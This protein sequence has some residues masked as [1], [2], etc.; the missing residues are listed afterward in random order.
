MSFADGLRY[1][2][3]S[4][5]RPDEHAR[6]LDNEIELHLSLDTMQQSS[7]GSEAP[8]RARRR[9]GN[10]TTYKEDA[11]AMSGSGFLDKLRQD[12]R[13]AMRTLRQS[14]TFTFVAVLTI[15]LGI[16]ATA[17]IFSVV[18][19][20]ILEPLPYP[21]AERIVA[22]W[23]D[24]RRLNEP[25]D[26][27]SYPNLMDLRSQN[28]VLSHLGAYREA[29]VN[30]TG[31]GEPQRVMAGLLSI[32][33]YEALGVRPM[34]G[35]FFGPEHEAQGNDGV[36]VISH[37]FWRSQFGGAADALGRD[38]ELN[39][40]KRTI[41]G[42]MPDR[43]AFPSERTQ[44]WIP[45]VIGDGLRQA[46]GSFAFPAVGRLA[47]GIPLDRART[48]LA[49]IAS[50]LEE[51]YPNNRDYGVT[52]TP[53]PEQVVGPTLRSALWIV[54]GAVTV[55]LLIACANVA[56]L[57]L[58]R[59]TARE[60]EVTVRMALGASGSRLVRQLLTESV[61]LS[62]LGGVAGIVLAWASLSLLR[63]LAP[64]D[65]PRMSE[66][67]LDAVVL[68]VT[69]GATLVTGLLFGMFPAMQLSNTSL[70]GALREGGRT[71]TTNRGGMRVRHGIVAAQLGAVVVLLTAAGLLTRTFITLQRVEL[72]FEPTNVLQAEIPLPAVRYGQPGQ[73]AAF[74]DALFE[75]LRS[76]PGVRGAGTVTTMF[77]SRTP[78]STG[79]TAEGREPRP[80]DIEVTFDV[81]STGFLE[82]VGAR[83]VAGRHFEAT[84]RQG[85]PP[86][87]VINEKMAKYYWPDGN[88]VGR[89]FLQGSAGAG[90]SVD[91]TQSPWITVVG[92]VADMRRTGVDMPVREE[93]FLPHAQQP[94]LRNILMIRTAG[95]PLAVVPQLRAAVRALDPNQ[96][97]ANVRTLESELSGLLAQRRFNAVL[98]GAF[99]VLALLLA[100]IGAYGVTA[101][102]VAQ[103]TKEIGVRMALGAEPGRVT[104][105]VVF[106]G[107]RVAAVGVGLGVIA[108][109]FAARLAT[110]LLH[111]VSPH[112][113]L[114]LVAAPLVLLVVVAVANYVPARR[115][116][117]VDPLMALR[118]E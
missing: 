52:V 79:I 14:P 11:R 10:V 80:E 44:I 96:P 115:A 16:G 107:L 87:A 18:K 98:V 101:Y 43:F 83:L 110:T 7:V 47:P 73:A 77:L 36:V 45:L 37:G 32:D 116:A 12:V 68:A 84:D 48:D 95:D 114:T 31:A 100:V 81:A 6:D 86:V 41:I 24:N 106:N 78:N 66:V 64:A 118:Q 53:L 90:G 105:L 97:L 99:A 103:R 33:A 69:S 20:V 34:V 38:L 25:Q 63:G 62:I 76:S 28:S 30:V 54:L 113:P 65:L 1:R 57:L 40:R 88:A 59:A 27:H 82:T 46:R 74:Y 117:R 15:A 13:F 89:R 26:I 50:R 55:V 108:A 35:R 42:I 39:G 102:L 70:A 22:V 109:F 23:M 75:T 21:E 92:V 72:G 111:G 112:D 58:S 94:T 85:V 93:V 29:G 9:F 2:L 49:T 67:R 61:L 104:R 19:A 5:F 51:Q 8:F 91:T 56:N 71:G 4:F 60:R 17:A 3:R